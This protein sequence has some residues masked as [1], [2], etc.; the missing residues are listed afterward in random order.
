MKNKSA[1]IIDCICRR[2]LSVQKTRMGNYLIYTFYLFVFL[3]YR[4]TVMVFEI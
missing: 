1:S 4:N 2:C 3:F